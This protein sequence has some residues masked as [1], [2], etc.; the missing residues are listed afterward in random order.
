MLIRTIVTFVAA[1]M[2]FIASGTVSDPALAITPITLSGLSYKDC[3][4]EVAAG[5]VTSGG[6]Y[7]RS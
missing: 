3:P 4:P 7:S 6:R 5:A 2:L 1:V